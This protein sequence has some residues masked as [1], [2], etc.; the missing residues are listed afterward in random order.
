MWPA[1]DPSLPRDLGKMPGWG[2]EPCRRRRRAVRLFGC[3]FDVLT[4]ALG[5]TD[6]VSDI[7]VCVQF[8]QRPG[9]AR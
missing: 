3:G 8:Y 6:V 5:V 1:R 2:A 7:M 9:G 4:V